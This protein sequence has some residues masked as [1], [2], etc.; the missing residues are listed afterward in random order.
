LLLDADSQDELRELI[1]I[2][3]ADHPG[4]SVREAQRIPGGGFG[5]WKKPDRFQATVDLP[6]TAA[7]PGFEFD[8]ESRIG[9]AAL[10]DASDKD[11]D[12]FAGRVPA[13]SDF[14]AVMRD[15]DEVVRPAATGVQ[16]PVARPV[17]RAEFLAVVG[18]S[19]VSIVPPT[20]GKLPGDLI[21]VVGL[22]ADA[23]AVAQQMAKRFG[24][25]EARPA[26]SVKMRGKDPLT[27][28]RSTLQARA[29]AVEKQKVIF[30][31][32]GFDG[33]G[34]GV[35]AAVAALHPDQVWAVV[36]AGRKTEDTARWV[37][38]LAAAAEVTAL[39]VV[40][41]TS[42]SSPQTVN[43]LG[44]PVGWSDGSPTTETRL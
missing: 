39:A 2:T 21:I 30:C 26:G 40:G 11:E 5:K 24:P 33:S 31:A 25:A 10:L 19:A 4:A 12:R 44:L 42:T 9:I 1:R 23:A 32:Y 34:D 37:N 15:L 13:P 8:T 20:P 6:A 3:R 22:P 27:D 35:G 7:E 41:T 17:E 29:D 38:D 28:R 43:Q 16:P 18:P 36:D 14:D